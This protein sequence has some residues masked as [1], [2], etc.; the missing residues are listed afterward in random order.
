MLRYARL[1]LVAYCVLYAVPADAQP[2]DVVAT[3]FTVQL[4][5]TEKGELSQDI[6]RLEELAV[7]NFTVSA[8]G[9]EGGKFS[10]F[11][12]RVEFHAKGEKFAEGLQGQV[13]LREVKTKKVLRTLSFSMSMSAP[14]ACHTVP[15]SCRISTARSCRRSSIPAAS[16]I[17]RI[18]RF[19]AANEQATDI[20]IFFCS[21]I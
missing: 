13:L 19:I 4:F 21:C 3:D 11:L 16:A 10:G 20:V 12:L 7:H 8:K 14:V 1:L 6:F 9:F 18:S 17:P 2:R 15:C 5:M